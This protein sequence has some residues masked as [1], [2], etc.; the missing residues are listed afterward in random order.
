[1]KKLIINIC[2]CLCILF[3]FTRNV[4]AVGTLKIVISENV[5]GYIGETINSQTVELTFSDPS[6]YFFNTDEINIG[7]DITSW[8][9]NVPSGCN[10]T[11]TVESV[12]ETIVSVNFIGSIDT[13]TLESETPIEVTIP[14]IPDDPI[15]IGINEEKYYIL[16]NTN[17]YLSSLSEVDNTNAKYIIQQHPFEIAYKGPYTVSG[18][19]GQE[20][21]PQIV[22]VEIISGGPDGDEFD[23][24]IEN[25]DL[26]VV[27]GLTPTV[28]YL[29]PNDLE[30][31]IT[32]TGIPTSPSQDLIHTTISK[33]NMFKNIE[34]RVVPDR[35]DVKF[36]IVPITM[37]EDEEE[38]NIVVF[39]PPHTGIE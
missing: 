16:Q 34:D 39:V 18:I 3:G 6:Q 32:Y 24:S 23:L 33:E 2:I 35:E 36:N 25:I 8:F 4:D 30:I 12:S 28:T 22:E 15:T 14:Y 26:P 1:M 10:Y 21:S 9:T 11:A 38:E 13:G 20:I 27:N 17:P 37:Q 19:V 31:T 7:D 5:E 29:N